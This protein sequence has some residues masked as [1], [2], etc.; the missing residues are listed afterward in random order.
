MST[1]DAAQLD[2]GTL[3]PHRARDLDRG[4][5]GAAGHVVPALLER[6]RDTHGNHCGRAVRWGHE[7]AGADA[8]AQ[9]TTRGDFWR[10]RAVLVT[11][12]NGFLGR[13]VVRVLRDAGVSAK[14]RG[15]SDATA[16]Y[17]ILT[18]ATQSNA[19]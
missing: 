4:D 5:G 13:N 16:L 18:T 9:R 15:T 10:D 3:V 11:G 1:G 8:G 7:M 19:A 2:V 6:V 17:T 14:L 12:G